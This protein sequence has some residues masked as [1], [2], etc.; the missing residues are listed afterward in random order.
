MLFTVCLLQ[1]EEEP[2]VEE[3]EPEEPVVEVSP[4]VHQV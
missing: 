4:D 1:A 3:P 2:I